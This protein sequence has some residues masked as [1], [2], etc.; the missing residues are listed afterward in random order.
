MHCPSDLLSA[1]RPSHGPAHFFVQS[2]CAI[3]SA[4]DSGVEGFQTWTWARG[5]EG[6]GEGF[7]MFRAL[8]SLFSL[9]TWDSGIRCCF[10][11]ASVAA[12]GTDSFRGTVK[13]EDV[14]CFFFVDSVAMDFFFGIV[15]FLLWFVVV[16]ILASLESWLGISV[17][18][19]DD[20]LSFRTFFA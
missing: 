17:S 10:V 18:G 16:K 4:R 19:P 1:G 14:A 2:A 8:D 12:H 20:F 3:G 11:V 15:D 6:R 9:L 5:G 7:S 13:D